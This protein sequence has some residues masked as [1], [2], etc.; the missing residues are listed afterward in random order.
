MTAPSPR[1]RRRRPL[2]P[3]TKAR[4][5]LLPHQTVIVVNV[6]GNVTTERDLIEAVRKGL[7]KSAASSWRTA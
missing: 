7:M 1:R 5:G 6:A 3:A 2:S 4:R